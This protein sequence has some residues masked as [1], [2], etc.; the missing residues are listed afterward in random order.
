MGRIIRLEISTVNLPKLLND[1]GKM[2]CTLTKEKLLK[3]SID[4]QQ[5]TIEAICGNNI[6]IFDIKERI[7]ISF[8]Q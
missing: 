1:F 3:L 5:K 7:G 2:C 6:F 8:R 4:K